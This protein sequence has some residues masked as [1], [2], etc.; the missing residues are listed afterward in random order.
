MTGKEVIK[1]L[2]QNGWI[3][4]RIAGSHHIMKKNDRTISVPVHGQ[5]DLKSGTLNAI[6][7]EARLK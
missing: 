2:K 4:D 3:L 6:L 1:K 7:K 5:K